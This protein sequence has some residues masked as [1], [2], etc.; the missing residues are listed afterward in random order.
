MEPSRC[1]SPTMR[2]MGDRTAA[3]GAMQTCG[4]A[5]AAVHSEPRSCGLHEGALC[6][7]EEAGV[8]WPLA[9]N[10]GVGDCGDGV[11]RPPGFQSAGTHARGEARS[12]CQV[13]FGSLAGFTFSAFANSCALGPGQ[14]R[15]GHVDGLC[16]NAVRRAYG[17]TAGPRRRPAARKRLH[18]NSTRAEFPSV[19]PRPRPNNAPRY[20]WRPRHA[21]TSP[22]KYK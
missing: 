2:G 22:A 19:A 21:V 14:S 4:G 15:W 8:T 16:E 13:S 20:N 12:L 1:C 18:A 17:G 5:G 10:Q 9:T 11:A 7:R 6:V 3:G